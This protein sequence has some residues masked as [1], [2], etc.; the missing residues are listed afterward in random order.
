MMN[1]HK[2][3]IAEEV[4]RLRTRGFSFVKIS[5]LLGRECE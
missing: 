4:V 5:E 1:S 3:A 2:K